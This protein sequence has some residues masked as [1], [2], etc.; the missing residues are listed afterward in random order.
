MSSPFEKNAFVH[1]PCLIKYICNFHRNY[2]FPSLKS[3]KS[4]NITLLHP[5]PS[6]LHFSHPQAPPGRATLRFA[7]MHPELRSTSP[8]GLHQDLQVNRFTSTISQDLIRLL[9]HLYG[10]SKTL[11]VIAV[12]HQNGGL[13]NTNHVANQRNSQHHNQR[14]PSHGNATR[15]FLPSNANQLKERGGSRPQP[16]LDCLKVPDQGAAG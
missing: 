11:S 13:K 15:P 4:V 1:G 12:A 6:P 2:L 10:P 14:H 3:L 16:N 8:R 5:L 9:L 7:Q